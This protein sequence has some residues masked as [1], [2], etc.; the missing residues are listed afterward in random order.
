MSLC[1]QKASK[2]FESS[3]ISIN[4][5]V[6]NKYILDFQSPYGDHNPYFHNIS[7]KISGDSADEYD[8]E[9]LPNSLSNVDDHNI[10]QVRSIFEIP[11]LP[12]FD[13]AIFSLDGQFIYLSFTSPTDQGLI[14]TPFK[15]SKLFTFI[16][17][18][19]ATCHW[20]DSTTV[21]YEGSNILKASATFQYDRYVSGQSSSLANF[22]GITGNQDGL[23][24]GA[25][26]GS[27]S[28]QQ[29]QKLANGSSFSELDLGLS[30]AAIP[31]FKGLDNSSE[32]FKSG[33]SI[34]NDDI[35][36]ASWSSEF[37]FL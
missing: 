4:I 1:G 37:K 28:A 14:F 13:H 9:W 22:L 26:T 6:K 31:K 27:Q 32:F 2:I 10:L 16:G 25:G 12:E 18:N 35:I 36:N 7:I 30:D 19:E 20:L 15:C 5:G 24:S 11:P 21:S 34:L 17:A 33:S 29:L 3:D 8:I 23:D